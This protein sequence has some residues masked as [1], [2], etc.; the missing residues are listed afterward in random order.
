MIL[1]VEI[2]FFDRYTILKSYLSYIGQFI[3]ISVYWPLK[4]QFHDLIILVI[5]CNLLV[6]SYNK[7]LILKFLI[8]TFIDK[9][10][11]I[12]HYSLYLKHITVKN[13]Y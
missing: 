9:Q 5:T 3:I 13:K 4:F 1:K 11:T 10:S 8:F 12:P 7:F 6:L 2:D